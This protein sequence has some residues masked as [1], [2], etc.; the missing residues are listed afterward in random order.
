MK[1]WI[2]SKYINNVLVPANINISNAFYG[3]NQL[4]VE[5]I[6]YE[7]ME[8]IYNW[9]T[10]EDIVVSFIDEVLTV[11]G[12]FGVTPDVIDY[13]RELKD[14]Y[15]RYIKKVTYIDVLDHLKSRPLFVK[16]VQ[17]K[18]FTG[19]VINNEYE[20]GRLGKFPYNFEF[21]ISE[22]IDMLREWRIYVKYSNIVD[23]RPYD[24]KNNFYINYNSGQLEAIVNAIKSSETLPA[25]YSVDIAQCSDG[26]LRVVE[27]ND[28]FALA[29]YGLQQIEYAKFISA[30]WAELLDRND[31]FMV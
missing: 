16:P 15:K 3:F 8:E 22:P 29:S 7:S 26:E 1:V 11:L 27:V 2:K 9:V 19:L 30:R 4:G 6:L 25:A 5:T 20:L 12:K 18:A 10:K 23:I 17:Q 28:G 24:L 14:F 21:F 13:P 31:L